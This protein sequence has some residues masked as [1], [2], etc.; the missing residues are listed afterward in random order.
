MDQTYGRYGSLENISQAKK[1]ADFNTMR[2]VGEII[3]DYDS[4]VALLKQR[5]IDSDDAYEQLINA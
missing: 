3:E 2:L 4:Y 5:E 1:I